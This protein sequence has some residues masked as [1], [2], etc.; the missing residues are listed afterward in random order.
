[1][2][3]YLNMMNKLLRVTRKYPFQFWLMF[4]GLLISSTGA[5]MI[6][7]FLMIYV[8]GKLNL[9]LAQIAS[10]TTINAGMGLVFNFIAGTATDK[11][12]RKW[13]MVISLLGNGVVYLLQSQA[14][15]YGGFAIAMA[16][17]GAFNPL[18]RVGADAMMADIIPPEQRAEGYSIMRMSNNLG[19]SLGPTIGGFIAA[20]SYMTA[21]FIAASGMIIYSFLILIF[22]RE[23]LPGKDSSIL[24]NNPEKSMGYGKVFKDRHYLSF[25]TAFTFSQLTAAIMWVLLSVYLKTN[26]NIPEQ[27]YGFIAATN[28]IMCVV[29]QIWVTRITRRIQPLKAMVVGAVFF[30][31]GVGSIALG[32][33]FWAFWISMVIMTIGELILVPTTTTYAANQAPTELRGRYM[34]IYSLSWGTATGIGP[35][36]GGFLNDTLGPKFIWVGGFVTGMISAAWFGVLSRKNMKVF[37]PVIAETKQIL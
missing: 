24:V 30:G 36:Y 11:I 18:Y 15:T 33:G 37:A 32:A 2:L 16:L 10:L 23:T 5:S 27:Q 13:V 26:Y 14:T 17:A 20:H 29:F 4:I 28:A 9:P 22:A 25:V 8:T 7:P 1:M 35:V 31:V 21:F 34:S 19:I 3:E 12:G 6:W